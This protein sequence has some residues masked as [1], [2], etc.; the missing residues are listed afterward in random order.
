MA[1]MRQPLLALSVDE[2]V[3]RIARGHL[4]AATRALSKIAR[5]RDA[6][7]LHAFRVAIR[8]LRSLIRAYRPWL[9]KLAARKVRRALRDLT[10]ATNAARDIDVALE[11]LAAERRHLAAEDRTGFDWLKRRLANGR[12]D[13]YR[14]A[15]TRLREDFPDVANRLRKR[16]TG[17]RAGKV[18]TFRNAW[19][20]RLESEVATLRKSL[21]TVSG[22]N[23]DKRVHKARIQNKRLRYLIEPLRNELAEARDAV[24]PLKKLQ[25]TLGELHDRNVL[26][27]ALADALDEAATEKA[28]RLHRMAVAGRGRKAVADARRPDEALGLVVLAARARDEREELFGKFRSRLA[29]SGHPFLG[30]ELDKLRTAAAQGR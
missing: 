29:A 4:D 2:A 27:A 14:L 7:N 13:A 24:R 28:R 8:R 16:M 5:S 18:P 25:K 26:E 11:W 23:D 15:A 1:G 3:A 12:G 10:R 19:L 6:K 22:A 9:G 17:N 21:S 30:A 20:E